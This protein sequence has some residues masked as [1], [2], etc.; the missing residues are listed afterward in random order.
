MLMKFYCYKMCTEVCGR[1]LQS[2]D[3][4]AA[5]TPRAAARPEQVLIECLCSR[6]KQAQCTTQPAK[7]PKIIEMWN[8]E[9]LYGVVSGFLKKRNYFF[10]SN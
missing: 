6:N 9:C 8:K 3:C 4:N 7:L 1:E 2:I 10:S 5:K